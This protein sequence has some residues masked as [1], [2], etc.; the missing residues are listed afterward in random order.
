MLT[1]SLYLPFLVWFMI[2]ILLANVTRHAEGVR[3]AARLGHAANCIF[4]SAPAR[5]M[6][7]LAVLVRI[8]G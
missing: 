4:A 2:T 5:V 6:L 1:V 7:P 3:K 8:L